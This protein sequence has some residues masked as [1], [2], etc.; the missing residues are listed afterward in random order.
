MPPEQEATSGTIRADIEAQAGNRQR[1]GR[2]TV[3][4]CPEC[5]GVLWQVEEHGLV[6]FVCHVGHA[7]SARNL[8]QQKTEMLESVLWAATRLLTEKAALT[9]QRLTLAS[10]EIDAE[11]RAQIEEMAR[12][13]EQHREM[14]R[15]MLLEAHPNP[16]EQAHLVEE[17]LD[18]AG[19]GEN[20]G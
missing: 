14:L 9:R 15:E 4:T 11:E 7:Y 3:Y 10:G 5:G 18:T 6:H 1:S 13:D 19:K 20:S 16:M 17:A 2:A 12:L 8:L